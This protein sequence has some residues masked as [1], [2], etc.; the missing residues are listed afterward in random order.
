MVQI[1]IFN[2][3]KPVSNQETT[4]FT[5]PSILN[6]VLLILAVITLISTI[7][8]LGD[9]ILNPFSLSVILKGEYI[10][11]QPYNRVSNLKLTNTGLYGFCR[12]PMQASIITLI[13]FSSNIY[14]V[15]RIIFV[16]VN[17]IGILIAIN[18]EEKNLRIKFPDYH[19]Y[20]EKVPYKLIPSLL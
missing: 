14:T 20:E 17:V 19:L 12:H 1:I 18:H 3:V 13:L 5:S 9:T 7:V 6:N 4:V 16:V 15:D 10:L 8:Q 2:Y 11:I